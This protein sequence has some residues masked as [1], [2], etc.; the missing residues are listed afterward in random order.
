MID[1]LIVVKKVKIKYGFIAR[2]SRRLF[3]FVTNFQGS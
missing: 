2:N 1:E 3:Y